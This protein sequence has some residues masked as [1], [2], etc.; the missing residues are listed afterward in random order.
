MDPHLI[1]GALSARE[2][3][4]PPKGFNRY[5]RAHGVPNTQTT[6]RAISA[7]MVHIYA[8]HA[9]GAAYIHCVHEKTVPLDNVR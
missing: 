2:S 7:A 8:L 4:P 6:L 1:H 5:C 3:L 9:G